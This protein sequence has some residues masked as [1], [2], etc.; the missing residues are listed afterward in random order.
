MGRRSLCLVVAS[1]AL[2]ACRPSTP[3]APTQT[4]PPTAAPSP[5]GPAPASAWTVSGTLWVHGPSGRAPARGGHVFGWLEFD[6]SGRT[7]GPIPL[8]GEGRFSLSVPRGVSRLRLGRG[9]NG[10]QPCAVT[11]VPAGD[12]AVDIHAVTDATR[13]GANLPAELQ[14]QSPT[15]SGQVHELTPD[16]GRI[17]VPNAWVWLDGFYGLGLLAADTRTGPDGRYVLCAIP[18]LP[19]LVLQVSADGFSL[20]ELPIEPDGSDMA[21]DVELRRVAPAGR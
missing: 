10:H 16:G 5:S 2:A 7:T 9:A 19:G 21:L 3:T 11:L 15:L 12:H 6:R 18:R 4:P 8:D 13:L 14:A 20:A 1:A 17:P